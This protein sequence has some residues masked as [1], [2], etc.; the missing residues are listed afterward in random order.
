MKENRV[1]LVVLAH[2][3]DETFGMGGTLAHYAQKGVAVHLVCATRGEAGTVAPELLEGFASIGDLREQELMCAARHLGLAGVHY[4]GHRDSGV[5]GAA[6]NHDPA[7]LMN[8]PVE[9]VAA[10]VLEWINKLHPQVVVTFD[11]IGGNRHP[12]HMAVNHATWLAFQQACGLNG[13]SF[14][15]DPSPGKLYYHVFPKRWLKPVL[16]LMPLFGTDPRRYGR[17]KDMD[18]V[19]LM[20]D[21]DFPVHARINYQHVAAQRE[22][23][24][25]CHA[26][27]QSGSPRIRKILSWLN[28]MGG[29]RDLYMRAYPEVPPGLRETDLF[30]GL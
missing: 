8:Q 3:D 7:A 6:D 20:Q 14:Q 16:L 19:A 30:E 25:N 4:L 11:P 1:M 9:L 24:Y 10:Q 29:S 13:Y 5:M 23:A 15:V 2:P 22:E 17:N 21:S 28:I 18:L 27:Q 12:D 26:S